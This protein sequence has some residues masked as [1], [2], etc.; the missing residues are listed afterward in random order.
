M[1]GEY[2]VEQSQGLPV[3]IAKLTKW[4]PQNLELTFQSE[5]NIGSR[6]SK[7]ADW[8]GGSRNATTQQTKHLHEGRSESIR[9]ETGRKGERDIFE[10][11]S[12]KQQRLKSRCALACSLGV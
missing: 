4:V 3:V 5:I 7:N 10:P 9:M 2:T 11:A 6:L 8:S 1:D 12:S